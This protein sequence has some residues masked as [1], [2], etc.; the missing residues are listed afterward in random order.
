[1]D[2]PLENPA[3][4]VVIDDNNCEVEQLR[5]A[6]SDQGEP[7]ELTVLQDGEAALSFI[8]DHR[9]G[10]RKPKPCAIALD[11]DLP[12]HDALAVLA[13]IKAEPVLSYIKV[14]VFSAFAE[15]ATQALVRAMGGR[16]RERP[17]DWLGA[18]DLSAQLLALCKTGPSETRR[19]LVGNHRLSSGSARKLR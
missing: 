12:K 14:L 8:A 5:R 17:R 6:L 3:Q 7:Y 10:L 18:L 1:M 4:I 19:A 11:L 2:R 13:A 16:Y 15:P 9:S